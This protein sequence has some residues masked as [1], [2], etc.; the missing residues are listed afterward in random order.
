MILP[1][2]G[3]VDHFPK[4]IGLIPSQSSN[5]SLL[6][7]DS[8]RPDFGNLKSRRVIDRVDLN[9]LTEF[10]VR[11]PS[12]VTQGATI[13]L[14]L[15]RMSKRSEIP[16]PRP[17]W[18]KKHGRDCACHRFGNADIGESSRNAGPE[19]FLFGRLRE[20]H[21]SRKNRVDPVTPPFR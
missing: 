18:S 6:Q 15:P 8:L 19:S 5:A 10:L 16:L 4:C 14:H 3:I 2:F 17:F 1:E 7:L 12:D 13:C 9:P 21:R 20:I 11:L